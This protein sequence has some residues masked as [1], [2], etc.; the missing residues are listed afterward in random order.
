MAISARPFG[1]RTPALPFLFASA[2]LHTVVLIS[3]QLAPEQGIELQLP[4]HVELG[5]IEADPGASGAP[6]PAAAPPPR[7]PMQAPKPPAH[8]EP[9]DARA[10]VPLD[11]GVASASGDAPAADAG[12][13]SA[14]LPPVPEDP[15][16]TGMPGVDGSSPDGAG[17]GLGFGAG[18]FGSGTGGPAGAVIALHADLDRIR[19][20]S[21]ILETSAL[22]EIIPEWQRLL[23]GSGLDALRDFSRVFVATPS[24]R[25]SQL[26]VSARIEGGETALTRA[27]SALAQDSGSA[28]EPRTEHGVKL[29]PWRSRGPTERAVGLFSADQIVI[30]RPQDIA[31]VRAVSAALALRHASQSG[32]E[33]ASGPAA[34]LSLYEGEAVAL[35]VEGVRH[36]LDAE[37]SHAPVGLRISLRHLDEY[38]AE[39]RVFGYYASEQAASAA[40]ARFETLRTELAGHPRA[41]YLGLRSAIDE[42]TANHQ[43]ST[44]TLRTKLT[45]HQTRY[46]LAFVSRALSPR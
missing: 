1:A 33:K 42:A 25:R 18:G 19:A 2:L 15:G 22:L 29:W 17:E 21:L 8:P 45:M 43:G 23:E 12:P 9:D 35:S 44:V 41:A 4:E 31:R 10:D 20:T 24:L 14:Q 13:P 6:P 36:F 37:V 7:E 32:M 39:L 27:V 16:A 11:A 3:G 34:L 40:F 46:L 5:L 30:A 38:N 28:A 26:V